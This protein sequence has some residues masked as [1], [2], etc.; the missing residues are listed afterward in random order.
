MGEKWYEKP[1]N[2][3]RPDDA[4]LRRTGRLYRCFECD[5][6]SALASD[7]CPTHGKTMGFIGWIEGGSDSGQKPVPGRPVAR[8][9][10]VRFPEKDAPVRKEQA[11]KLL[12]GGKPGG[13]R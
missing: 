7:N 1:T 10:A 8:N 11:L 9:A 5:H 2:L 12:S 4:A 6:L 3:E 13:S